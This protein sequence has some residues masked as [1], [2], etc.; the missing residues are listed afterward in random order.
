MAPHGA[1]TT[2]SA[3]PRVAQIKARRHRNRVGRGRESAR[4]G[5]LQVREDLLEDR[6]IVQRADQAQPAP[7]VRTRQDVNGKR[8]VH[9]DR[10]APGTRTRFTPVPSRLGASGAAKAVGSGA[11]PP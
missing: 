11:T 3:A 5:D 10:P 8:P 9:E 6:R 4:V 1:G 2:A 7:T